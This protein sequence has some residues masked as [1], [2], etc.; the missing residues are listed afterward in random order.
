[1]KCLSTLSLLVYP[2][3]LKD[4]AKLSWLTEFNNE[5]GYINVGFEKLGPEQHGGAFQKAF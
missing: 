1:M 2:T 4:K 3:Y 5:L